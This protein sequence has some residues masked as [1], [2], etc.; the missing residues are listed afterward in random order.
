MKLYLQFFATALMAGNLPSGGATSR[1]FPEEYTF[2][3]FLVDFKKNYDT[4]E[5]YLRRRDI[6]QNKLIQ[7]QLHNEQQEHNYTLGINHFADMLEEELPK[8]FDKSYHPAYSRTATELAEKRNLRS[9][10]LL[11][12]HFT[13]FPL[14]IDLNELPKSVD[15][16]MEP[17]VT[18]AVKNQGGCGSCWAFAAT[19]ALESHIAIQTGK[20]FALSV[21]ELVSCVPNP[22]ACGGHG[23][24]TGSTAEL[25]YEF[26]SLHGM[27]EEWKFAYQSFNGAKINCT[28][29]KE[30][31]TKKDV[32]VDNGVVSV[33]GFS[34]LPTNSYKAM[35][36]AV[37]TLGPIVVNVAATGWGMYKSGIFNDDEAEERDV[38]HAVVL[39]G[40]GTDE[41]TGQ[42]YWIVRNSWS[43]LWGENGRI[44]LKRVDPATLDDPE[45]DCKMDNHPAD[46][47]ACTK[48][49]DGNDITPPKVKVCGTS[50]ILFDGVVPLG[51]HLLHGV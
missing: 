35:M 37:A 34:N 43:P 21:Q 12:P 16:R 13:P 36:Y 9:P 41:E 25:A 48:D 24:C 19:A 47:I 46:G 26:I 45:K 42:D 49:D 31:A 18:T 23:G 2:D 10:S 4:E 1:S 3:N 28:V 15:W 44:R 40:Y 33:V 22:N 50:A 17:S 14:D 5:E 20:L 51:G 11:Q 7:I 32:M 8:G 38:N 6:F 30:E 27:V 39:E 29:L